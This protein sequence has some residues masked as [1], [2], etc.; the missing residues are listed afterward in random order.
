MMREALK[1]LML[2]F[3][4]TVSDLDAFNR[5]ICGHLTGR[6][7]DVGCGRKQELFPPVVERYIGLNHPSSSHINRQDEVYESD[8]FGD[9]LFLPFRECSFD[10]VVA[11]SLLE[12]L[13]DP[14]GACDE[15]Y[16][17]LKKGGVFAVTVPFINRIHLAPYDFFRFTEYGIRHILEKS[18]FRVI[19][20]VDGG[21]MFKCIGARLAGYLYSDIMGLGYG[22]DDLATRP[23]KYLLPFLLPVIALIVCVFRLLDK[24]HCVKK[25]TLHYYVLCR[26]ET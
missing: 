14:Q 1:R 11:L 16:R 19:K 9:A 23:K 18:G 3:N 15:A 8:V 6:L 7:L 21:G 20:L 22:S 12:H 10:S 2:W 17:V 26:K 13:T 25:D 5:D 24:L 4:I